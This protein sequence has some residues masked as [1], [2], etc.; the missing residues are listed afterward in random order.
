MTDIDKKR[1]G[2]DRDIEFVLTAAYH[3]GKTGESI[4][5][6]IETCRIYLKK[7]LHS[8]G[9]VIKVECNHAW[10]ADSIVID[11][12]PPIYHRTCSNCREVQSDIS[13]VWETKRAG[14]VATEPLIKEDTNDKGTTV[15]TGKFDS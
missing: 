11:T 13:G 3:A 5:E 12:N 7:A 4:S 6:T 9:V 10:V 14:Y 1:E 8:Q 2:I 15:Y